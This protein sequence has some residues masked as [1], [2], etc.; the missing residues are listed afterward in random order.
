MAQKYRHLRW[1]IDSSVALAYL[2]LILWLLAGAAPALYGT[3]LW[4]RTGDLAP[5]EEYAW[6]VAVTF[7]ASVALGWLS[8]RF[9]M[10]AIDFVRLIVDIETGIRIIA[11]NT[12][13]LRPSN[14]SKSEP[15]DGSAFDMLQT[16]AQQ[17]FEAPRQKVK[18][19]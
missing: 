17:S 15:T 6:I 7:P 13:D 3:F 5:L 10:A 18:P 11:V 2:M 8:F 19:R 1:G 14:N 12:R 16:A 4:Y 9:A